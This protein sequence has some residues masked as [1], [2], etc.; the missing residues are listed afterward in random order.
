MELSGIK[1]DV[2]IIKKLLYGNGVKGV[3]TKVDDLESKIEGLEN[4]MNEKLEKEIEKVLNKIE[5]KRKFSLATFF[6]SAGL[7]VAIALLVVDMIA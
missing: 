3:L 5:E 2:E 7:L 4:Y 1:T 6:Q